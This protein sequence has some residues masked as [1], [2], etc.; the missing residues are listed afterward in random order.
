M[1]GCVD[2][3][4]KGGAMSLLPT[5]EALAQHSP[6][7]GHVVVFSG[8][9]ASVGRREAGETVE[10]L[11]GVAADDVT[12]RT[13]MLVIGAGGASP[14]AGDQTSPGGAQSLKL[15][16]AEQVNGTTPGRIRILLEEDF[17]RLGGLPSVEA[18]DRQYYSLRQIR[19]RYPAVRE[20]HLR[21]LEK[22]SFVRPVAR[23]N[24]DRYYGFR[25]L[26]IVRRVSEELESGLSFRVV[27]R[28]LVAVRD[29]QL[30]LDFSQ[31]AEDEQPDT[32]VDLTSLRETD[33]T[34][35]PL[36][37]GSP[38]SSSSS[39]EQRSLAARYFREGSTLDEGGEGDQERAR[40]AYRKALLLD[41]NLVPALVNLA[42]IY[43]GLDE[44]VEAQALYERA[45]H[46]DA[47]CFEAYFNLG[48]IHHDLGRYL[49]ALEHYRV[50]I[51]INPAYADTHF[52]LAVTLEKTGHSAEAKAHWRTYRDLAPEGEWIELAKEFSE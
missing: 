23:T 40:I 34:A 11:G 44:F 14:G 20:D 51:D 1:D 42:N 10:R 7:H 13:T 9:L 36:P 43:Y 15:R 48:N 6:F 45:T 39:W 17:C 33:A 37:G 47:E 4:P 31:C 3:H 35:T 29:G 38:A 8:K 49:E 50:S 16:K 26:A 18:L 46:L 24:T 30:T 2:T 41:P 32:V 27:L 25:D 12:A 22:W 21:Y 19:D 52:Y 28:A 5:E